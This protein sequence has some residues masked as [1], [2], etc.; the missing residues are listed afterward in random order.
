[1]GPVYLN[2]FSFSCGVKPSPIGFWCLIPWGNV[3][4]VGDCVLFDE[5]EITDL[6]SL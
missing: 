4:G 5:K 2:F 1:M 6:S 3:T